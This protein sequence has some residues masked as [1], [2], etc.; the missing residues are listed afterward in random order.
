M[1]MKRK[2]FT[3]IELLVVIAIIALLMG[4]LMPALAR[5]RQ[6]A[7]RISCGSNLS[8]IG[9]AMLVYAQDNGG[10]FPRSG[11]MPVK[12]WSALG[13]I[14]QWNASDAVTAYGTAGAT[15]GSC[16]YLLVK[17]ADVPVT[18]FICKGDSGSSVFQLT[19]YTFDPT[20]IKT[21]SDAWDFGTQPGLN[22]S[23]SLHMPFN[24]N[25][26][27]AV[28]TASYPLSTSSNPACAL[29]ADRNPFL[30]T[31]NGTSYVDGANASDT[32]PYWKGGILY[33]PSRTLNSYSHQREGQNVTFC[34]MHV[35]FEPHPNC[36]VSSDNIWK[37]WPT[38]PSN[39]PSVTDEQV[40]PPE[41]GGTSLGSQAGG[42]AGPMQEEDSFLVNETQ[43]SGQAPQ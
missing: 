37:H 8:G 19:Q 43:S 27:C 14:H 18:Q 4:L 38:C 29:C 2:G 20:I 3:L 13:Y 22:C 10:D 23:Y 41:T 36:G 7:A 34:D 32:K 9:K 33:D 16:F 12:Q 24:W 15:I 17:Y 1:R 21:N 11:G 31:T 6:I 5:V 40:G 28:G 30:D 35:S 42:Q 25:T 26:T 39:N